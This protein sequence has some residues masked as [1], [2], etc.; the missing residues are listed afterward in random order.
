MARVDS[1]PPRSRVLAPPSSAART[2]ANSRSARSG[3]SRDQRSAISNDR[4]AARGLATPL[5]AM[6]GAEPWMGS[7]SP[8]APGAPRAAE[9][10]SPIDPVSIEASSDR[11]SPNRLSVTITSNCLGLRTS[12]M[13]QLSARMCSSSTSAYSRWCSAV[14]TSRQNWPLSMTFDF[15]AEATLLRRPRASS[16][17]TRATRSISAV[18]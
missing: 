11:M 8:A 10:S 7:Y 13:A 15:S 6:S 18:V 14:T 5:P 2:A 17:A 1:A 9:G 4:M 16:K 3:R 12:C